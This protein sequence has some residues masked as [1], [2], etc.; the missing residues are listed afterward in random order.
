M[1]LSNKHL[2]GLLAVALINAIVA[3]ASEYL[4]SL[5]YRRL[6]WSVLGTS[7]V[8]MPVLLIAVMPVTYKILRAYTGDNTNQSKSADTKKPEG[9]D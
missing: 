9:S 5:A 1:Q 2:K 6:G 4:A 8:I 7:A 3:M